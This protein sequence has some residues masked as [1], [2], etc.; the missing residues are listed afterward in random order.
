MRLRR[1]LVSFGLANLFFNG[2]QY[3][4]TAQSETRATV[5]SAEDMMRILPGNTLLAYDKKGPFWMYFP[6]PGTVWGQSSNGD[7]DIGHWWIDGDRYCRS[8]R[9]WYGGDTQCWKLVSYGDNRLVWMD[10]L[11]TVQGES[12]VQRGNAIGT[13]RMP[14]LAATT[15]ASDADPVKDSTAI[16]PEP[17][18]QASDASSDVLLPAR[19]RA[20]VRAGVETR[21]AVRRAELRRAAALQVVVHRATPLQAEGRQVPGPATGPP[22]IWEGAPVAAA[23]TGVPALPVEDR[24]AAARRAA[25]RR[26]AAHRRSRAAAH[27]AAVRRAAARQVA[28]RRVAA[29]RVAAHRVAAHPVAA[30]RGGVALAGIPPAAQMLAAIPAPAVAG[31]IKAVPPV[32]VAIWARAAKAMAQER[33]RARGGQGGNKGGGGDKGG[34]GGDKGGKGRVSWPPALRAFLHPIVYGACRRQSQVKKP[35]RAARASSPIMVSLKSFPANSVLR[36]CSLTTETSKCRLA[37]SAG[38]MKTAIASAPRHVVGLRN[39]RTSPFDLSMLLISAIEA[40]L[41]GRVP[42][43]GVAAVSMANTSPCS[44]LTNS[45]LMQP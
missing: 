43:L 33:V 7:V 28:A 22:K 39:P 41:N 3:A 11:D 42:D 9:V 36:T 35:S 21:A 19:G 24:R 14:Q 44:G 2:V 45:G 25:V 34:R 15:V 31:P 20:S 12:V 29:H 5:L 26:A 4:V 38:E 8:W 6:E 10:S 18:T 1:F 37:S 23:A 17:R 30:R 27:R 40:T 32:A 13:I 16:G